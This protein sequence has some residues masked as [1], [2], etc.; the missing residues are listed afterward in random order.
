MTSR[1]KI[2]LAFTAFLHIITPSLAAF[3]QTAEER[4]YLL[5]YFKEEELVVESPTRSSKPVTRTAE[6]VTVVTADEI[7]L[8]NAHTVAEVLA[9]VTGVQVF[10]TGGPGSSATAS[11]QGSESRH[12]AVFIDGIPLNNLADNTA[13]LGSLPVQSIEKIEIIKGPASSA[14]GS[15]LGG[16]INIITKAGK[17]GE[18]AGMLSASYGKR[19]TGDFRAEASGKAERVG[20]YFTV[21]RLETDGF[22]PH[23]EFSGDNGYAKLSYGISDDMAVA[24]SVSYDRIERGIVELP[25]YGLYLNNDMKTVRSFVTLRSSLSEVMDLQMSAWHVR[26]HYNFINLLLATGSEFSRDRYLDAGYGASLKLTWKEE[27][28]NVVLGGEYASMTLESNAIAG[29]KQ[30]I[31]KKA[32][33]VNDTMSFGRLT[34]TPGMRYDRTDANGDFTS[35]SLGMTF[36]ILETTLLRAY[37]ARG[38][39]VPPLA[40][41]YG[42]SLFHASNPALKMEKVK[43]FQAGLETTAVKYLWMKVSA[44]KNYVND[45][46]VNTTIPGPLLQAV[47][48]GKARRE[49]LEIELKTA[50]LFNVSLTAGASFMSTI[51]P[52][53]GQKVANVPTRTYDAGLRHDSSSLTVLLLGHYIYWNSD[54]SA[55]G[56]YDSFT[57]DL[58]MTKSLYGKNDLTVLVYMNIYNLLDEEQYRTALYK[59]PERWLEAGLRCEF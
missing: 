13:E 6:N 10:L 50:P 14:W 31:E 39:S 21:G 37:V 42:D 32:A 52:D 58:R 16:V 7:M 44:N 59:N 46:I 40:A 29:N 38:F 54:V 26:Q 34:V 45:V 23:N 47:N 22:R 19:G 20:Y 49:G 33:F 36:R 25:A 41:T 18:H 2:L 8:M 24:A 48:K 5:M 9:T 30:G 53:T 55:D 11:I 43:S 56:K 51:D 15:A 12:V 35:P 27:H 57:Y 28:H 3:A 1:I 4:Q 17:D